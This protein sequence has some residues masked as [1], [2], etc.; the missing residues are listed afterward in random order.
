LAWLPVDQGQSICC[1]FTNPRETEHYYLM[2]IIVVWNSWQIGNGKLEDF[3]STCW[4]ENATRGD[5][6]NTRIT[7]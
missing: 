6:K 1:G 4:T 7:H 2:A 5:L 3:R